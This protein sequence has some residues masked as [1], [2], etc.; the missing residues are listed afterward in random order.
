M[1]DNTGAHTCGYAPHHNEHL[2]LLNKSAKVVFGIGYWYCGIVVLGF[3]YLI[4]LVRAIPVNLKHW[5]LVEELDRLGVPLDDWPQ[6]LLEDDLER[7]EEQRGPCVCTTRDARQ[8]PLQPL[9]SARRVPRIASRSQLHHSRGV[10]LFVF[11]ST[12]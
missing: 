12:N 1:H 5:P 11:P 7:L 10:I 2:I 8:V 3:D 6:S 9:R 4:I